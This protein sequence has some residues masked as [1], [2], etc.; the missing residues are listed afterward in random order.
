MRRLRRGATS[1]LG[2][3]GHNFGIEDAYRVQVVAVIPRSGRDFTPVGFV[4]ALH[5]IAPEKGLPAH[6]PNCDSDSD[7]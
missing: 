4:P 5:L 1:E 2:A 7:I 6:S 3:G